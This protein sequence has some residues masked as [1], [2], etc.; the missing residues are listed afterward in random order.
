MEGMHKPVLATGVSTGFY[1][2]SIHKGMRPSKLQ[3][4]LDKEKHDPRQVS[5]LLS[6]GF[7]A[8]VRVLR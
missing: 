1:F 6:N 4:L 2:F 8:F 3:R 7:M 5:Q